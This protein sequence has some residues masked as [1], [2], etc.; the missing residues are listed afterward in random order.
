[1][2][3][4]SPLENIADRERGASISGDEEVFGKYCSFAYSITEVFKTVR[5]FLILRSGALEIEHVLVGVSV[6]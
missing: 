1:M 5:A 2:G 4:I 3:E 6:S